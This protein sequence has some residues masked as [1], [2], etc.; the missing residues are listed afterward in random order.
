MAWRNV[1]FAGLTRR[2]KCAVRGFYRLCHRISGAGSGIAQPTLPMPTPNWP[3]P[4]ALETIIHRRAVRV[5]N[6]SRNQAAR[7]VR[8]NTILA[9][10]A[11]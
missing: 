6:R 9:S 2:F 3:P 7:Y 10:K 1:S 8:T 11:R 5:C 4:L